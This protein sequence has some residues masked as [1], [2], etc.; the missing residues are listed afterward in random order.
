M[1]SKIVLEGGTK[2]LER[3]LASFV[4]ELSE[5][6]LIAISE[7][8]AEVMREKLTEG[9][10]RPESTGNTARAIQAERISSSE[11]GVGRIS[12]VQE[13]NEGWAVLNYGSSHY[14]GKQMRFGEFSPG[15]PKPS[16]AAFRN[17]RWVYGTPGYAPL[18]KKPV[19]GLNYIEKTIFLQNQ[20]VSGVFRTVR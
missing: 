19:I 4:K 1:A 11:Y 20:I 15:E 18:V 5:K 17:G 6:H 14:V 2:N 12:T 13:A 8:S 7:R 16:D 3:R 10:V 9:L